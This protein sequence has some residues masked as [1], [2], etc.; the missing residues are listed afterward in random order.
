MH[1]AVRNKK[2]KAIKNSD[3][4]LQL[5]DRKKEQAQ[6]IDDKKNCCLFLLSELIYFFHTNHN[7]FRSFVIMYPVL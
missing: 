2:I 6:E 3:F 4:C 5:P 1:L 7:V